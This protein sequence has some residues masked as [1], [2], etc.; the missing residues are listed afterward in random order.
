MIAESTVPREFRADLGYLQPQDISRLMSSL[1]ALGAE[2]FMLKAQVQRLQLALAESGAATQDQ[3]HH[4][5]ESA[6]FNAWLASE[7]AAF[8]RNLLDPFSTT[9]PAP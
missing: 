4:A 2:V 8:A 6:A 5:G 3:L 7:Q 9:P 1:V